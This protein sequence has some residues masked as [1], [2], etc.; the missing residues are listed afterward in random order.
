[1]IQAWPVLPLRRIDAAVIHI[2][3]GTFVGDT[4]WRARI[5]SRLYV[6]RMI[7]LLKWVF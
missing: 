5:N 7:H 6:L 4:V 2:R 1:M 3:L